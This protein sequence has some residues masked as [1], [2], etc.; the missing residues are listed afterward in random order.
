MH[1]NYLLANTYFPSI[2]FDITRRANFLLLPVNCACIFM[3]LLVNP[4]FSVMIMPSL[5]PFCPC[6]YENMPIGTRYYIAN[7]LDRDKFNISVNSVHIVDAMPP[8]TSSDFE[9]QLQNAV[10]D[11]DELGHDL[12]TDVFFLYSDANLPGSKHPESI[13]P[14]H[15]RDDLE[16]EGFKWFVLLSTPCSFTRTLYFRP[17]KSVHDRWL[18]II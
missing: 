7:T 2:L 9:L 18:L 15:I 1:F 5:L 13:H 16:K 3:N 12:G 14:R 8:Q 4:L 11:L 6:Y 17:G 10:H